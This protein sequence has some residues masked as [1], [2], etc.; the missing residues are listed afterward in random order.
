MQ[1]TAAE[2]AASEYASAL[3]N[4]R[5]AL[6]ANLASES[7]TVS[8]ADVDAALQK[9]SALLLGL[10]NRF[11]QTGGK[12]KDSGGGGGGQTPL[13]ITGDSPLRS[14]VTFT[15]QVRLGCALRE[16]ER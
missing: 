10:L 8:D 9:Y 13:S 16:G 4:A 6:A 3:S 2:T 1:D 15:W 12:G 14:A 5:A 7:A 11:P